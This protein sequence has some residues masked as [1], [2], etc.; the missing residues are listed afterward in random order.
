MCEPAICIA[1]A[2]R[3]TANKKRVSGNLTAMQR[4]LKY[5]RNVH[6]VIAHVLE[7]ACPEDVTFLE[8]T[9]SGCPSENRGPAPW[10]NGL[11]QPEPA[12]NHA[13]SSAF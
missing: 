6:T 4:I 7:Y 2:L 11:L 12:V 1:Y 5:F 13:V 9:G 3:F 8:R 10:E